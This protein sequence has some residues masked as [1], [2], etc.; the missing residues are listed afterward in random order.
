M[1]SSAA[2][3]GCSSPCIATVNPSTGR[4]RHESGDTGARD[5]RE[6][7]FLLSAPVI[8][9]LP[10]G[11]GGPRALY[12]LSHAGVSPRAPHRAA[13][14]CHRTASSASSQLAA[15]GARSLHRRGGGARRLDSRRH[16]RSG[17][18]PGRC[19]GLGAC[20]SDGRYGRV[21]MGHSAAR[22]SGRFLR[23][24]PRARRHERGTRDPRR[25]SDPGRAR[26]AVTRIHLPAQPRRARQ[27]ARRPLELDTQAVDSRRGL[28]RGHAVREGNLLAHYGHMFRGLESDACTVDDPFTSI[29]RY[30]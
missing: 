29:R 18:R 5:M 2:M 12:P 13:A 6:R 23:H 26:T 11:G 10:R 21:R 28:R 16:C 15:R 4:R 1:P 25:R 19:P 8:R 30:A 20:R 14:R 27:G 17:R 7:E 24:G 9:T 22:K 3:A